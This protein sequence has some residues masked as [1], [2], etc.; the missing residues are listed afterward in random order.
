MLKMNRKAFTLIELLVV[1]AI[2]AIL[3]AILF[4]VFANAREKARE[5]TC[6]SNTKQMLL[7]IIQYTSDYDE[8]MPI[9][10][11]DV[12]SFGPNMSQ[13]NMSPDY[14]QQQTGIPIE[15]APYTKSTQLFQ[16]PDDH[17][18]LSPEATDIG[19]GS[20]PGGG[21]I[22]EIENL[23]FWQVYGTSYKF[24]NQN[25]THPNTTNAIADTGYAAIPFCSTAGGTKCDFTTNN[26]PMSAGSPALGPKSTFVPQNASEYNHVANSIAQSEVTLSMFSR[27]SETRCVGDWDKQWIDKPAV[28]GEFF[29]PEGTMLG[30]VDG[31]AKFLVSEGNSY[32]TGCDGI[33]WA[34]DYAG[35]CN[36]LGLQRQAD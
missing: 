22:T 21:A 7:G 13:Y 34:W 11:K 17:P 30:F 6:V 2:I 3:A 27:P 24:T 19:T 28:H 32:Y 23:Y 15:I 25:Y 16:C 5:T 1:I 9:S 29:H 35:S 12:A 33:D 8:G 26:E 20:V 4:P 18:I 10:F 31:H 14:A 36:S